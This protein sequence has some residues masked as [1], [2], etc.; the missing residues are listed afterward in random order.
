MALGEFERVDDLVAMRTAVG[1]AFTAVI[2]PCPWLVQQAVLPGC[3]TSWYTV[4]VRLDHP[5]R[6]QPVYAFL[7]ST[8][9]PWST[10]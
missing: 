9:I 7:R 5:V 8:S 6:A 3:V 1:L 4:G 2:E 10:T